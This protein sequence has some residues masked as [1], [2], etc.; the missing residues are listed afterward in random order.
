MKKI[1]SLLFIVGLVVVGLNVGIPGCNIKQKYK[2]RAVKARVK[3]ILK[4]IKVNFEDGRHSFDEQTAICRWYADVAIITDGGTFSQACDSFD[5][6]RREGGLF[7]NI[8]DFTV[9]EVKLE[10]G[11]K[12]VYIVSG[13]VDGSRYVMRV[14]DND[15]VSWLSPPW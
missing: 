3:A 13:T 9:E 14:P 12:M 15:T 1:V 4:G 6:W 10:E 7:P 2:E 11:S 5:A 8:N